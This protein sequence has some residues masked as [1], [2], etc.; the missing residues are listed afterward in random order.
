MTNRIKLECCACGTKTFS[1]TGHMEHDRRRVA[2]FDGDHQICHFCGVGLRIFVEDDYSEDQQARVVTE[3]E[4][5]GIELKRAAAKKAYF[6][7]LEL[8]QESPG[9]KLDESLLISVLRPW[10]NALLQRYGHPVYLVGSAMGTTDYTKTRDV[11]VVV[12]MP[13]DEFRWRFGGD[14]PLTEGFGL[15]ADRYNAEM[16]KQARQAFNSTRN[17]APINIDFKVQ[18]ETW[19]AARHKGKLKV[20]IDGGETAEQA[21]LAIP[22]LVEKVQWA[23]NANVGMV[24]VSTTTLHFLLR[25]LESQRFRVPQLE[26]ELAE[27][28]R[29][30]ADTQL[31]IAA[32]S[33]STL[34]LDVEDA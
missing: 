1:S 13:D 24:Q 28:S 27:T 9:I 6:D 31:R 5:A 19:A 20:R 7:R 22:Q 16:G 2:W 26:A 12:I 33:D 29:E 11:D 14:W 3:A 18:S 4:F 15:V 32:E 30:L 25:E 8:M 10:A 21:A 17:K 34:L 23:Q